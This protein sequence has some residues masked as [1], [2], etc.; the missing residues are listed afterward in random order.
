MFLI[1]AAFIILD[2][3]FFLLSGRIFSSLEE[4]GRREAMCSTRKESR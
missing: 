4:Y 2:S 3:K 1:T